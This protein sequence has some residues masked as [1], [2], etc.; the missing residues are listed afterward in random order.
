MM[1]TFFVTSRLSENRCQQLQKCYFDHNEC[2][3]ID[4]SN[5]KQIHT[6]AKQTR[7]DEWIE[8]C[9]AQWSEIISEPHA[10]NTSQLITFSDLKS[11]K[12]NQVVT[13]WNGEIS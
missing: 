3:Q 2:L 10:H 13:V 8:E 9:M 5:N 1:C 12:K 6:F 7:I 4:T 11:L